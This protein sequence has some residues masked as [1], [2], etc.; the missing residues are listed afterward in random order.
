MKAK[1]NSKYCIGY[2]DK[3]VRPMVLIMP[4]ISG[5]LKLS[6][7]LK[8]KKEIK[9]KPLNSCLFVMPIRNYWKNIKLFQ[10]RLKIFK[11]FS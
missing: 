8:L 6:R 4:K 10:L 9:T 7:N 3:A 11:I 2:L 1:T 5:Y